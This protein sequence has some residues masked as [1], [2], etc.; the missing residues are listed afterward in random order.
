MLNNEFFANI[1]ADEI[2]K[3]RLKACVVIN[4]KPSHFDLDFSIE[5]VAII[6]CDR[7][8]DDM[9]LPIST[10]AHLTVKFGKE[11]AEEGDDIIIIPEEE[12]EINLAWFLYEF[13]ALCIPLKHVHLPGKCNKE[14]SATLK[15]HSAKSRNDDDDGF[16]LNYLTEIN[17]EEEA[18]TTDPRWD[19]LKDLRED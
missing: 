17:G 9:E 5:G 13:V 10:T 16:A 12:G 6:S 2:P 11:F 1:E 19:V 7:C 18:K 15:K 3:G 8:L 14:M 4:T